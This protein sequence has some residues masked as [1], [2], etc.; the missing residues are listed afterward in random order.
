MRP[1][2]LKNLEMSFPRSANR[3]IAS[4]ETGLAGSRVFFI[5]ADLLSIALSGRGLRTSDWRRPLRESA[6]ADRQG[7]G[8]SSSV[9][10]YGANVNATRVPAA[11]KLRV[12]TDTA[13]RSLAEFI[14]SVLGWP[15]GWKQRGAGKA[16]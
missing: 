15:L 6:R 4:A 1:W 2:P 16:V 13:S 3:A 12:S 11:G 14:A 9:R 10:L 7:S 8:M 5:Q